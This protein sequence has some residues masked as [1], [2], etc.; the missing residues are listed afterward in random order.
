MLPEEIERAFQTAVAA[1]VRLQPEG[2]DRFRVFTP[3]QFEDRD[4]LAIVLRREAGGWAL[5]DEGHTFMHVTYDIGERDLQEGTRA[6]IVANALEAY[7]VQDRD[8]EL[9]LPVVANRFGDALY[10]YV[11]VLLKIADV[12]YL[13]RE[14][15]RSTFLDDFRSFVSAHVPLQRVEFGWHDSERDP[16]AN[17]IVD[18][19]INGM[20]RPLFV[21]ALPGDDR[22]RDATI[23]LLQFERWRLEQRSVAVFEDQEQTNRR[24]LARFSDVCENQ[25]SSLAAN[26]DRIARYLDEVLAGSDG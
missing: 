21:F 7:A 5:S 9:V 2:Q 24:V 3:F 22:V 16:A 14:R 15:T 11:Q 4:H 18:C 8:G 23:S 17:Y 19:R 20:R 25:F 26:R 10:D 12:N 13:S 6:R 1:S